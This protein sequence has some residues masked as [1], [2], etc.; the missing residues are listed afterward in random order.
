MCVC[1][2][3]CMCVR[4]GMG[5]CITIYYVVLYYPPLTPPLPS[6]PPYL[7]KRG[8]YVSTSST[9][10]ELFYYKWDVNV[11]FSLA[12]LSLYKPPTP[13]SQLY[14]YITL[15]VHWPLVTRSYMYV[16]GGGVGGLNRG[17]I[18]NSDYYNSK[19]VTIY[20]LQIFIFAINIV[21]SKI[22]RNNFLRKIL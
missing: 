5:G 22:L 1:V 14:D 9:T 10:V 7:Y 3:V 12:L 6:P 4:M 15:N 2:G 21:L 8:V 13:T 16:C 20:I 18:S 11:S 19:Y 17:Y